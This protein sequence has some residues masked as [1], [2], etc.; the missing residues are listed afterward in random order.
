MPNVNLTDSRSRDA[1]V[2]AE[3]IGVAEEVR[4][5]DDS[6]QSA[7]TRKI[8][9]ATIEQDFETLVK[10]HDGDP[11]G[12]GKALIE[13][14][15]EVDMERCGQFLWGVSKV[16]VNSSDGIV[17]RIE[18]QE[19]VRGRDGEVKEKRAR[20]RAEANVDVEIPLTWT[21]RKIAKADA[22]RRFV[23]ASK[24]QIVHINGLTYDFL[25]GMAK[26]LAE[27]D[28]LRGCC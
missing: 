9:K 18:Q 20:N 6:G 1:I 21:G 4:Y 2:K 19:I 22:V 3:N 10:L 8:L 14:D 17:Y 5:V 11:E 25:Y 16:Y 26:E 24:L 7:S 27:A 28:S 12:L 15:P 23:F 13:G